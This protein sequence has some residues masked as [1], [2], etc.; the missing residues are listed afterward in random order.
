MSSKVLTL[1]EIWIYPIKSLG[2]ILMN[3]ANVLAKGLEYDRRWMLIDASGV[4]MSQRTVPD[5]AL[6]KVS[7]FPDHLLVRY[8]NDSIS[9]PLDYKENSVYAAKVWDDEVKVHE[10]SDAHNAWF[11][12]RLGMSCKLVYFPE[13][14]PREVD[15]K[16]VETEEHTGLSDGYPFLIIGQSSLNDLNDRLTEAVPMNRFRPNFVFTGGS[17]N[18]EDVWKGFT[19]GQLKFRAVKPCSRCI[20]TT[21]DQDTAQKGSEPLKTLSTYRLRDHKVYFG[22]NVIAHSYGKVAIGDQ[23]ILDV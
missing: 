17:P 20:L 4:F 19:V 12:E 1:S 15:R 16:Y 10:V 11:S 13:I 22:Q 14:N 21:I 6:F 5:M 2:G 8:Q 23:I 18:E 7:L 3:Q 9:V